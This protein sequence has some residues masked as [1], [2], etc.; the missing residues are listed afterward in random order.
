LETLARADETVVREQ[1]TKSLT[2]IS[3]SLSDSEIQNQFI[4]IVL[5]LASGEWFTG[6]VS[7]CALFF[8]AYSRAGPQKEKLRKKFVELCNEDTPMIRR[9]C[10]SKIG[11]SFN[12]L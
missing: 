9:A 6:R 5:K 1:A 12:S 11:V 10:A 4:A 2:T 8:P 7:S 3:K